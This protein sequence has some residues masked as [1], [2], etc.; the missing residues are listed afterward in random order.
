MIDCII[1]CLVVW[2]FGFTWLIEVDLGLGKFGVLAFLVNFGNSVCIDILDI[3]VSL[4]FVGALVVL[5]IWYGWRLVCRN[6]VWVFWCFGL[7]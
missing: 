4:M 2:V 6:K 3:S 5:L 1:Q 7:G